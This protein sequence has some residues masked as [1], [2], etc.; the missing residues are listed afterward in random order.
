MGTAWNWWKDWWRLRKFE[1]G[2]VKK[3]QNPVEN[4]KEGEA[5]FYIVR[6]IY[7]NPDKIVKRYYEFNLN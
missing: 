3:E 2:S 1:N 7:L 6:I 4:S 5:Y